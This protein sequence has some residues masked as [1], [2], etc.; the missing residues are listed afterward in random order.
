MK[1]LGGWC[2]SYSAHPLCSLCFRGSGGA[3][4]DSEASRQLSNWHPSTYL[5]T[6]PHPSLS[7]TTPPPHLSPFISAPHIPLPCQLHPI[8]CCPLL[9]PSSACQLLLPPNA[10]FSQLLPHKHL[11]PAPPCQ[12]LAAALLDVFI[13]HP[14]EIRPAPSIRL[15][16]TCYP[17]LA[18]MFVG[19]QGN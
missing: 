14:T 10:L 19:F 3:E 1:E 4:P 5:P 11:L 9:T 7:H 6:S 8:F 12:F 16:L 15:S 17:G 2:G 13:L 18:I